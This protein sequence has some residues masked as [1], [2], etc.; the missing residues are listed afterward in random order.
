M[1]L[2]VFLHTPGG[3]QQNVDLLGRVTESDGDLAMIV[4]LAGNIV[5]CTLSVSPV[6]SNCE[7]NNST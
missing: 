1:G 6:A 2:V 4:D 7:Q 3:T 5:D